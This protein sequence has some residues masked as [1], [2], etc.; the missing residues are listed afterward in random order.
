MASLCTHITVGCQNAW[1]RIWLTAREGFIDLYVFCYRGNFMFL[2]PSL[3]EVSIIYTLPFSRTVWIVFALIVATLTVALVFAMRTEQSLQPSKF[4]RPVRW[5]DAALNSL[6][7]V[8]Q[9]G[10]KQASV[11]W[12][13]RAWWLSRQSRRLQAFYATQLP[14]SGKG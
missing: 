8:C 7:I 14:C 4:H 12:R 2:K 11:L 5:S 6:G 1:V 3:S 9:Q 10:N 13:P